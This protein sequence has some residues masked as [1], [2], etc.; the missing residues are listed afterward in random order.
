MAPEYCEDSKFAAGTDSANTELDLE[1]II[2]WFAGDESCIS[3]ALPTSLSAEQRQL[4]K[5][6]AKRFP[7]LHCESYGFGSERR[8][9]LFKKRAHGVKTRIKNT[10]IDAWVE[11][12]ETKSTSTPLARSLPADLRNVLEAVVVPMKPERSPPSLE[13]HCPQMDGGQDVPICSTPSP[14]LSP[15]NLRSLEAPRLLQHSSQSES[16]DEPP[17]IDADAY[18]FAPT[19]PPPMSPGNVM[20]LAAGTAVEIDGLLRR[21]DFNGAAGIVISWD[22]IMRRYNILLESSGDGA[23]PRQ[24]KA[25]REN[26]RLRTPPPP[27]SSAAAHIDLNTCIPVE[28]GDFV[29]PSDEI[30]PNTPLPDPSEWIAWQLYDPSLQSEFTPNASPLSDMSNPAF[31][32]E[33]QFCDASAR[34]PFHGGDISDNSSWAVHNICEQHLTEWHPDADVHSQA[35]R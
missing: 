3:H 6:I 2:T 9:H 7:N 1:T 23:V 26:L 21:P 24:V 11:A 22:P 5:Q 34:S 19:A 35:S 32:W 27:A 14:C 30:L 15:N 4:S 20:T 10:F 8:L 25:K 13:N 28:G 17:L 18:G 12:V 16:K 29:K 33:E 31:M